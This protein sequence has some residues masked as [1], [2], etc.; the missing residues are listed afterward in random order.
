M[1]K[2]LIIVLSTVF[3]ASCIKKGADIKYYYYQEGDFEVLSKYLSINEYPD[4]YTLNFPSYY[5]RGFN[6]SFDNGIATLGRVLFYDKNLSSDRSVSCASC[7]KQ[8][9]AFSDDKALSTGIQNRST[10]RNSLAL[11]STFNFREYYGNPS[12]GGI[13][14]FWDNRAFTV[15]EQSEQTLA[16]EKEMGMQMHEVVERVKE[17]EYYEPLFKAEFGGNINSNNVLFAISEFV[18]ALAS[19]ES[20]FDKGLEVHFEK[21]NSIINL[22]QNDFENFTDSENRGKN[23]Y[24]SKCASCHSENFGAPTKIAANNGLYMDYPDKGVGSITGEAN[25]YAMFKVPTLRNIMYTAPY[26]HDGSL[27]TLEDVIDHYSSGIQKHNNL[28]PELLS[29]NEVVKMNFSNQ[30]KE[31]L[32]AFFSTLSEPNL[33]TDEKFS[34]PFK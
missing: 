33:M 25:D 21:Y 10:D 19:F 32:L 6:T 4:D 2:A 1:K 30:D 22:G 31:D 3:I 5:S 14:F 16:N 20:K 28:S 34:D 12:F 24:M 8:E 13:P 7:H 9:L 26:M 23:I 11:G 17:L 18:N 29:G 27:A 15:S